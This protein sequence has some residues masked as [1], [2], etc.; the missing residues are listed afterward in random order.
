MKCTRYKTPYG[1]YTIEDTEEP[2]KWVEPIDNT[3]VSPDSPVNIGGCN[4]LAD[5]YFIT[6]CENADEAMTVLKEILEK[7]HRYKLDTERDKIDE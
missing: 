3:K 6:K 1:V 5:G 2:Y 4:I 7:T